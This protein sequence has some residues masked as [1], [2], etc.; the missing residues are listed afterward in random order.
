MVARRWQFP[1]VQADDERGSLAVLFVEGQPVQE[2]SVD[3]VHFRQGDLPRGPMAQVLGDASSITAVAVFGPFLGQEQFGV[4]QRL[5]AALADAE[6]DADD[7]VVHLA[8]ATEIPTLHAGSMASRLQRRGLVDQ[9]D[10][11]QSIVWHRG[12]HRGDRA[13]QQLADLV[14]L[15]GVVAEELLKGADGAAGGQS[16]GFD[17]LAFEFG[18]QSAAVGV[19]M[20]EGL[21]ISSAEQVGVQE[22]VQGCRPFVQLLLGHCSGLLVGCLL[23]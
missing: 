18:D 8:D 1:L 15:P 5:V 17:T 19:P 9:A 14:V 11:A 22:V 23:F 6:V 21:G 2:H 20:R 7:A 16:D 10:V 12:Q 13:L 3:A 4:H